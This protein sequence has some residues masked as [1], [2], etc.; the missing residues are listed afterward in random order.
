MKFTVII[1]KSVQKQLDKLPQEIYEKIKAKILELEND[2]RPSGIKKLV[3]RDEYRLRVGQYRLIYQIFE[4][5]CVIILVR[6]QHRR[7]VYRK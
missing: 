5:K 1:P 7:D 3:G 4:N 6:C 2:P